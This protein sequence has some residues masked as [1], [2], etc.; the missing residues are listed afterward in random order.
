MYTAVLNHKKTRGLY[1]I[2]RGYAQTVYGLFLKQKEYGD[3]LKNP[4]GTWH[5]PPYTLYYI[6]G[7]QISLH[8]HKTPSTLHPLSKCVMHPLNVSTNN[9]QTSCI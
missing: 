2:S 4:D 3:S 5:I 7:I 8:N 6:A 1:S 9:F